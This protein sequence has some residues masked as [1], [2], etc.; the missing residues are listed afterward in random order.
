MVRR[1]RVKFLEQSFLIRED[2][3]SFFDIRKKFLSA[4][5]SF[6]LVTSSGCVYL[7]V[8]GVGAL[9]GYIVSPDTVEGI[10][11]DRDYEAVWDSSVEVV[12]LIGVIL[13][14]S[15]D[16]GMLLA[17]VQGNKVTVT[18]TPMSTKTIKLSIKAR[19]AFLPKITVAQDVYIK[20][21]SHLEE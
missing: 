7:I 10:I 15:D 11:S 12:S 19:K 1:S 14:R 20:I 8:G 21:V 3:M 2:N 13:E 6:L 16:A 4:A 18:V 9:G 5:L 17:K